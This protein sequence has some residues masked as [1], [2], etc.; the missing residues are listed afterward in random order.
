MGLGG[1]VEDGFVGVMA[2]EVHMIDYY[3]SQKLGEED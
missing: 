1:L 3:T 2:A